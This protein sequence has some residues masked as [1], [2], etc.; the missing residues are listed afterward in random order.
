MVRFGIICLKHNHD[1]KISMLIW[2]TVGFG[3][4]VHQIWPCSRSDSGYLKLDLGCWSHF[5]HGY[6]QINLG[7]PKSKFRF[8]NIPNQIRN[9]IA[10]GLQQPQYH[11]GDSNRKIELHF[12]KSK[13]YQ[14]S[15]IVQI[16]KDSSLTPI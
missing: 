4:Q 3:H 9:K 8:G 13:F 15:I 10:F 16:S 2:N 7:S 12:L 1:P 5:G 14:S 6:S 11:L